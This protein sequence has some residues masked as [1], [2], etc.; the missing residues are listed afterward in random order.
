M[1]I[2]FIKREAFSR[3]LKLGLALKEV[4]DVE[5]TLVCTQHI[6]HSD[7]IFKAAFD[8]VYANVGSEA[9]RFIEDAS[10]D[11]FHVFD[12]ANVEAAHTMR[13]AKA[14]VVYDANDITALYGHFQITE[15]E[16]FCFEHAAG[17]PMKFPKLAL[18]HLREKYGWNIRGKYLEYLDYCHK[19]LCAEPTDDNDPRHLCYAGVVTSK[20][21]GKVGL[22]NQPI[23]WLPSVFSQGYKF[24]LYPAKNRYDPVRRE[25]EQLHNIYPGQFWLHHSLNMPE[26]QKTISYH[27]YGS[28]IHDFRGANWASIFEKTAASHGVTTYLEAGLPIVVCNNLTWQSEIVINRLNCGMRA[29]FKKN[30]PGIT[31]HDTGVDYNR[32]RENVLKARLGDHSCDANVG[33]LLE[34]YRSL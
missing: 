9:H 23:W 20:D 29:S 24:T 13:I 5:T 22:I 7:P 19:S 16:Q 25:Y 33:R 21:K 30:D 27:G 26:L 8:H 3:V 14:P 6:L 31:L 4:P 32:L 15:H 2:T 1:K 12:D 11:L 17:F 34:F 10:V 18:E 28:V